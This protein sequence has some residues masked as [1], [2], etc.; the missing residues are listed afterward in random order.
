MGDDSIQNAPRGDVIVHIAVIPHHRFVRQGDDL[1]QEVTIN[2]IEAMLG[3]DITIDTIDGKQFTGN[4]PQGTQPDAILG[5]GGLGMPNMN[6]PNIRGRML[7]K[8]KVTVP[9]LDQRQTELL[10]AL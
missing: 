10:K 2:A 1:I 5:I 3:K 7:L 4:I 6:N 8:I 9:M